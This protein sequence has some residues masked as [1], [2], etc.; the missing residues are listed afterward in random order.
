MSKFFIQ[1]FGRSIHSL[2]KIGDELYIEATTNGLALRTVNS[3][4]S[5]F[6]CFLYNES[7]FCEYFI[8]PTDYKDDDNEQVLKWK[9]PMKSCLG[10]FKS[11][12][13]IDKNVDMCKLEFDHRESRL[14]FNLFCKHGIIKTYNLTFQESESLQAV[15]SRDLNPNL[16]IAQAKVLIDTVNNFPNSCDEVT[17]GCSA[18]NLSLKNYLE[19][20]PDLSKVVHTEMKMHPDEFDTYQI[21]V[22]AE[23]TFCL[24]EARAILAFSE[25]ANQSV[26]IRFSSGGSPIIFSLDG[27]SLYTAD[28]VLATL[29]DTSLSTSDTRKDENV[30]AITPEAAK[31]I[32]K[33]IQK[34][35][36][37]ANTQIN[38]VHG[39]SDIRADRS[40][41]ED[42]LASFSI[43]TL[44]NQI[45]NESRLN[46]SMQRK[47]TSSEMPMLGDS[48]IE[49]GNGTNDIADILPASPPRKKKFESILFNSFFGE[50]K[51]RALRTTVLAYDTDEEH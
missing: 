35:G 11:L 50:A 32:S 15:F 20:E 31:N 7:F 23:I 14:V 39:I 42:E 25:F 30:A 10:V 16:I 1:V 44:D 36:R 48:L 24:K 33:R 26:F 4:R 29:V 18:E 37:K 41:I 40:G 2:S 6:G 27:D 19:D 38:K 46:A 22:D 47:D 34:R 17:L 13:T 45:V 43:P 51:Q 49:D 12:N 3:A 8:E 5:A 21:G 28:F 9:I